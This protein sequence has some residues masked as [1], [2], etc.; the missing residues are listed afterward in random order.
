MGAPLLSYSTGAGASGGRR[1]GSELN[2]ADRA[3]SVL[4]VVH[5]IWEHVGVA[6]LFGFFGFASS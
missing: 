1:Q 4:I 5:H 3:L 2:V 6:G